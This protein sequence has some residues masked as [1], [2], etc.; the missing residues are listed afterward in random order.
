MR[1]LLLQCIRQHGAPLAGHGELNT[2]FGK[3][4]EEFVQ[5][6]SDALG[7]RMQRPTVK[8]LRDKFRS[9]RREWKVAEVA[10]KLDSGIVEDATS[11]N[12]LLDELLLEAEEESERKWKK[13][14]EGD[15][16]KK[17]LVSAG[18]EI[19][20]AASTKRGERTVSTM[21][22]GEGRSS[23]GKPK[24]S[25]WKDDSMHAWQHMIKYK[26]D[27]RKER[28]EQSFAI[29]AEEL[30]LEKKHGR[31]EKEKEKQRKREQG[32]QLQMINALVN[33]LT[34]IAC[35]YTSSDGRVM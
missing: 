23:E 11:T 9:L 4:F 19:R 24:K 27:A 20:E 34:Q 22:T 21:E 10:N 12:M 8:T 29:G 2:M 35:R 32:V 5:N 31:D 18:E 33:K 1:Q 28:K 7:E 15:G 25:H 30:A 6:L 14:I 3:V 17:D 16:R 26:L 13:R